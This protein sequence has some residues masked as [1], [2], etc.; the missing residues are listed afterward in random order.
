[1]KETFIIRTE[2]FDSIGLI[3]PLEQAEIFRNLFLYHLG[4]ELTF[5]TLNV[6]LIFSLILPNLARNITEY[7]KRRDTS[8]ENGKLGGRPSKGEKKPNKPNSITYKPNETLSVLVTDTVIDTVSVIKEKNIKKEILNFSDLNLQKENISLTKQ[9]HEKLISD[10]GQKVTSDAI[11]FL[12]NYKI[13]KKYKTQSDNL[14]IRRWVVEAVS[15]KKKGLMGG[16]L[17]SELEKFSQN[18]G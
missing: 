8:A 12:S 15:G 16:I 18:G 14:T 2:W 3:S 10:Y 5:S 7:D 13:E 17:V 1:M 9:E 11:I 6:K 4:E